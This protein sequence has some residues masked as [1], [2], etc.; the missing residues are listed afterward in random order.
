[1]SCLN[2]IRLLFIILCVD[3][4]AS[5]CFADEPA[6]VLK[7]VPRMEPDEF[8][9]QVLDE[10]GYLI[11]VLRHDHRL[12]EIDWGFTST[13]RQA[14]E[15]LALIVEQA[16]TGPTEE[17]R[18]LG[19]R[20][21]FPKGLV[22]D[23]VRVEGDM[24]GY[25]IALPRQYL[26]DFN[27][28][29]AESLTR[30]FLSISTANS[31]IRHHVLLLFD[32]DE[33][34]YFPLNH[35]LTDVFEVPPKPFELDQLPGPG[36]A[37]GQPPGGGQG[38][39][40]G[41]LKGKSIFISP[42]H[43]WYYNNETLFRWATQRP[44]T[45]Y[46]IEDMSNVEAVN[47]YLVP[48]LW[49]A[50]AGVYTC[51][52]RDMNTDMV[53]VDSETTGYSDIG[54]WETITSSDAYGGSYRRVLT[55]TT[56]TATATFT[57]DIPTAG[58]YHV[59]VW[60]PGFSSNANDMSI[61]INHTGGSTIWTQNMKVDGFTFKHIGVYYFAAG[62]HTETGSVT[63]SNSSAETGSYALADAVRFGGGVGDE[64]LFDEL[65]ASGYP[66]F[67]ESGKYYV[68]F[69]GCASGTCGTST[70]TA[71]P[72]YSAWE[73]EGW[74][75]A[76]YISWHSNAGGGYGTTS[77]AYSS[78]GWGGSFDGYAGGDDLRDFIHDEL[79]N[80]IQAGFDAGWNDRGASTG[81]LGEVNP[82]YNNEMPSALFE[83]AF[84]DYE[85]DAE[86]LRNPFFRQLLARAV[87][88]GIV[89]YFADRDSQT[90]YYLLPE[91]PTDFQVINNGFGAI[92]LSWSAPAY[93]TGD[94]LYGDA[95]TGY[96]VYRSTDGFGFS[97]G[98]VL[99]GVGNTSYTDTQVSPGVVYY[100][101]VSATNAGGE[102]FPTETLAAQAS[103]SSSTVLVVAGFDRMHQNLAVVTDDLYSTNPLHRGFVD[104][105]NSYRYVIKFAEAIH[106]YGAAFDSCSNETVIDGLIDLADYQA[107]LWFVGEDST[108]DQTFDAYEQSLIQVYLAGGGNIFVSG[109]EIGWDLDYY[110]NGVSFYNNYLKADYVS[111]DAETY[112]VE[113]VTGSIFDGNA[114]LTFDD[115]SY[116]EYDCNYPDC[117]TTSGGST[118][119]LT[120]TGGSGGNAGVQY[121][122]LDFK[123]V[124]FGFT[125]ET[126]TTESARAETMADILAFFGIIPGSACDA[127]I[128]IPTLPYTDN[129]DS[130]GKQAFFNWY[131]CDP[132]MNEAGPEVIY[133]LEL[134]EPGDLTV[135]V[136]DGGG[137]DIDPH[138]LNGCSVET[139]LV[140]ADSTF[141][142]ALGPSSYYLICDTWT[143]SG[144]TQYP[145]SYTLEVDLAPWDKV[146]PA[147]VENLL[148]E[149]S[150]TS[151]TWDA[152]ILDQN[153]QPEIMGTYELHRS[154]DPQLLGAQLG[155]TTTATSLYDAEE[156]GV[157]LCWFFQ[158]L[159]IDAEGNGNDDPE[160]DRIV[161][162]PE[163]V[164]TGSWTTGTTASGHYGDDYRF[165]ATGGSG[166]ETGQ[167][168]FTPALSGQYQVQLYYPQGTNRSTEA[169]FLVSDE[170]ETT[171]YLVNQQI[172]GGTWN[173]L[174][175]HW[176]KAGSVYTVMLDDAESSGY[177][178]I[179]DAVRWTYVP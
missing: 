49:N 90:E 17:E 179:A 37:T 136:T 38:Q 98:V 170:F 158:V 110:G 57:P 45:Y 18:E 160:L 34:D 79:I 68:N 93:N 19:Y 33:S 152:V 76:V 144:G 103:A 41:G 20:S 32:E 46:M 66:R 16:L 115:N 174:G 134:D 10:Q 4:V 86:C 91:P 105:M 59:Y 96:K 116:G 6:M 124:H 145:G 40:S 21:A 25:Y 7:P 13:D 84:H 5:L 35:F 100:Y 119:C 163:A 27:A 12:L 31:A 113:P 132:T 72:R 26:S 131:S 146:A 102:S 15:R 176:F 92:S 1:M 137:V 78:G 23:R 24:G 9:I 123:V 128:L 73:K 36:R 155:E 70:V 28:D 157:G 50:G 149:P 89:K 44:N 69:M 122:G 121:D 101:R 175:Y 71:M 95:A 114:T 52:E 147:E 135:T 173:T 148:W 169:R 168:S 130:T 118:V 85:S 140:R 64:I 112:T 83:M 48:Y 143:D 39:P 3:M 2:M 29:K 62:A 74:E 167:W 138:I 109:S 107:V 108:V 125:F 129:N 127:A 99:S 161:D 117:I 51:R 77:Y 154:A 11:T 151:W 80:D 47:T 165:H 139:C 60:Y 56:E 164:F 172:N 53:I 8:R 156:P 88:Q 106:A 171:L 141:I 153:G 159:P 177:V 87:Y 133:Q 142:I 120:Y 14:E 55:A 22:L 81:N 97:N 178:V 67:E 54:G 166:L 65:Y 162:N 104:M 94:D 63:I 111:D 82:N 126:V 58:Y 43:G 30:L 75:D 42:G 150:T 61:T